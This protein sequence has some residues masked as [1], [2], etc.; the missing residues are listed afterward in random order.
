MNT[1][2]LVHHWHARIMEYIVLNAHDID[3]LCII[4]YLRYGTK[5]ALLTPYHGKWKNGIN[6][7]K[8]HLKNGTLTPMRT[9]N[10]V[11]A[12]CDNPEMPQQ[13]A[14]TSRINN[15]I[16]ESIMNNMQFN[17]VLCYTIGWPKEF[18]DNAKDLAPGEVPGESFKL[19]IDANA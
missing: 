18:T 11:A 8:A 4:Q 14:W 15:T 12:I 1:D 16:F 17:S 3:A 19:K 5:A 7:L 10:I 13:H 6:M 2:D 9:F